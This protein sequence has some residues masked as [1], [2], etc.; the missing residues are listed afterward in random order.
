MRAQ[1]EEKSRVETLV[2]L[3]ASKNK[4][5][6]ERGPL[7]TPSRAPPGYDTKD[8]LL[9][10]LAI[11]QLLQEGDE[12]FD[13]LIAHVDDRRYC[14]SY[15][16]ADG[17]YH[18]SVGI[19]CQRICFACIS[20]HLKDGVLNLMTSDKQT[21]DGFPAGTTLKKW[22]E[23]NRRSPLWKIQ[24]AQIGRKIDFLKKFDLKQARPS[25]HLA[26]KLPLDTLETMRVR[27]I[28]RLEAIKAV[29]TAME[30]PYRPTSIEQSEERF[31]W[32][33][34]P[35]PTFDAFHAPSRSSSDVRIAKGLPFD[36][37]GGCS[38]YG[39]KLISEE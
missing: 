3:L 36:I 11:Q 1:I 6:K 10:F 19:V 12:A 4:A 15:S 22:W 20:P 35:C 17:G 2:G 5:P 25:Q 7:V 32:L 21:Y 30:E 9:V 31:M 13:E 33:P 38:R 37:P 39:T 8:Q 16:V 28:A 27:D 34:W 14:I 29:V 24:I 26:K 23:V 18:F